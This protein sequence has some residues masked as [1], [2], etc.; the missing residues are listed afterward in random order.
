[1]WRQR[2]GSGWKGKTPC[3]ECVSFL[4]PQT[5]L[6]SLLIVASYICQYF[7]ITKPLFCLFWFVSYF[8]AVAGKGE[9]CGIPS[10]PGH[11]FQFYQEPHR[12]YMLFS[13]T[14]M[15]MVFWPVTRFEKWVF[16]Q[17]CVILYQNEPVSLAASYSTSSNSYRRAK[18][19]TNK[20]WQYCD[21]KGGNEKE[22]TK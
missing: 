18:A 13:L 19:N 21:L 22:P 3:S 6:G 8:K 20:L 5:Q 14:L 4:R 15:F 2:G 10:G 12:H 9:S 7:K 11:S 17:I 16:F 1:M